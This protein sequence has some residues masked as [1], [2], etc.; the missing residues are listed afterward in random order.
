MCW[1]NAG[2]FCVHL[3][4]RFRAKKQR[5]KEMED[6]FKIIDSE[7]GDVV[8]DFNGYILKLSQLNLALSQLILKQGDLYQLNNELESINSR[9][10]PS[11][12][13]GTDWVN[14]GVDCQILNPGKNWQGGKF[15]I[16]VSLE[17]CPNEPEIE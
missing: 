10:L 4:L 11:I 17:F 13:D 1:V 15:R 16:K 5:K 6:N 14:K 7:Q 12:K 9:R 3:I 8:I 2:F